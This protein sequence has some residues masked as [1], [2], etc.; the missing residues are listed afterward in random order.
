MIP[1][2]HFANRDYLVSTWAP[3]SAGAARTLFTVRSFP[4][5]TTT[6]SPVSA[7]S[8]E[9]LIGQYCFSHCDNIYSREAYPKRGL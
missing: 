8:T 2:R 9:T 5:G 3:R 6:P 4:R 7:S 1:L